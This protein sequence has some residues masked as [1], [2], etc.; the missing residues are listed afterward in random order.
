MWEA[1]GSLIRLARDVAFE[2]A[3]G[4]SFGLALADAAI[5]VGAC[6]GLVFGADDRDRVDGVVD[7]AIATAVESVADGL[8]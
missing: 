4:F 2:G 8:A 5:E 7:L 6:L 3:H 1:N